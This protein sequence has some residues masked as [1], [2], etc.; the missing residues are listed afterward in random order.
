MCTAWYER[1]GPADDVLQVSGTEE[2]PL[3]PRCIVHLTQTPGQAIV[4]YIHEI[5]R[6]PHLRVFH[7]VYLR[8]D[9]GLELVRRVRQSLTHDVRFTSSQEKT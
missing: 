3:N 9:I 7:R 5:A 8:D 1:H 2:G 4:A 6:D